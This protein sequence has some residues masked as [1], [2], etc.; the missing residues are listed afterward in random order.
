MNLINVIVANGNYLAGAALTNLVEQLPE[1]NLVAWV[2]NQ[3]LL[4]DK[5][6]LNQVDLLVIDFTSEGF[7]CSS[8]QWAKRNFQKIEVTIGKSLI[9]KQI[10][11]NE[12]ARCQIILSSQ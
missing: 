7:D 1:F 9:P 3:E 11:R 8:I 5:L 12:L 6:K 4:F 10:V 2:E